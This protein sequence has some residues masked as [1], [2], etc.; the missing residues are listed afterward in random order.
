MKVQD[1]VLSKKDYSN[2]SIGTGLVTDVTEEKGKFGAEFHIYLK[3]P[4]GDISILSVWQTHL[5]EIAKALNE[6]ETDN[7]KGK[8]I[9]WKAVPIMSNKGTE[10]L[11]WI[12][13]VFQQ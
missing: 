4:T 8:T 3:M 10:V 9:N 12:V 1:K 5:R 11:S 13:G 6:K 2:G 7:W